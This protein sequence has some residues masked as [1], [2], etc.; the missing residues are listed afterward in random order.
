MPSI[1][2]PMVAVELSVSL[3]CMY[4]GL[5]TPCCALSCSVGAPGS[6]ATIFSYMS[7]RKRGRSLAFISS[8]SKYVLKGQIMTLILLQFSCLSMDLTN[9]FYFP[10]CRVLHDLMS[11][12][13]FYSNLVE[14]C[15]IIYSNY[16]WRGRKLVGVNSSPGAKVH[17]QGSLYLAKA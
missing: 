8:S 16:C 11:L 14:R 7:F 13:C 10:S 1:R 6:T 9:R 12:K 15:I 2:K 5:R 17:F 3:H 4:L